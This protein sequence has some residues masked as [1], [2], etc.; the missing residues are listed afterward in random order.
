MDDL[1][2]ASLGTA[3]VLADDEDT[4]EDFALLDTF[5]GSL[6]GSGRMLVA[7][8]PDML[9]LR[10]G[11]AP[12]RQAAADPGFVQAMPYGEVT[13][14]LAACVDPLRVLLPLAKGQ[15][16]RQG[17][18]LVDD[19]D[20]TV[21]RCRVLLFATEAGRRAALVEFRPL[22]GYDAEMAQ[23]RALVT[24]LGREPDNPGEVACALA[25][26][27]AAYSNKPRVEMAPTDS[28]FRVANAVIRANLAAARRNEHGVI[29]DLDTEFL[30]D[31][32][33][34]LRRIR[35]VVSLF[36]GV[37]TAE[38]TEELR[39]RFN[40][41]MAPTGRLRDL[42]VYMLERGRYTAMAPEEFR[43]G[44]EKLFDSLATDR[45][46]ARRTLGRRLRSEAYAKEVRSLE[47][48]VASRKKLHRGPAAGRDALDF[49]QALTWKRYR[50]V[51]RIAAT[52]D[53]D[54]EDEQIH[55]LRIQ[56]KKLRY[57][58]EIFAPLFD[59]AETA[60]V[61]KSLKKLQNTLGDFNDCAVQQA[62]LHEMLDRLD[63]NTTPDA[64]E[65]AAAVGA[66]ISLLH[67]RQLDHRARVVSSFAAFDSDTTR[68]RVRSLFK[69][70]KASA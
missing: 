51:C 44:L 56:C 20:K 19:L 33:V 10:A 62:E 53:D 36:K 31:Y 48:L 46:T 60:K 37:Y 21:A 6:M 58:I 29:A 25:G 24:A 38:Q 65:I 55:A 70:G 5:D 50:K 9:L 47:K 3:R 26:P 39:S 69:P 42:D 12:L 35:S 67:G 27:E 28:A 14:E 30:H 43:P 63:P 18:K 59:P 32:R 16:R 11:A 1:A 45:E 22:R 54:T 66:L 13:A 4:T 34:A 23:L 68:T 49:A 64:V 57:L 17:L 8:G 15:V 52:I 61:L 41:L 7:A 2:G 40:A